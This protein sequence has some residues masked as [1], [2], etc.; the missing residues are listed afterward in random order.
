[1]KKTALLIA[2][3]PSVMNSIKSAYLKIKDTYEY[4]IDFA[5][6]AG[7]L[8]GLCEPN[9][10][11]KEWGEPWSKDVLPIVPQIWKKK[12][13]NA[14]FFNDLKKIWSEKRYDVVI[15]A[16][17]AGREGQLI[18][19]LVYEALGV[20]VPILRYWADDTTEKTIIKTLNHLVSDEQ[21]SG[22]TKASYLRLYFDWLIGIN[23]SRAGTLALERRS[24]MGRVLIPTLAL[25]YNRELEIKNFIPTDYF[26]LSATFLTSE[27][28]HYTG[29]LL[30]PASNDKSPSKYAYFNK[31]DLSN[32]KN[33]LISC[34]KGVITD[35]I[36]EDKIN[37]AP[38]L[39]NLSDLQKEC[40]NKFGYTPAKTLEIAQKLY[41]NHY[42]SYPRTESK[43]ITS[44]QAKEMPGLIVSMGK[45]DIFKPFVDNIV[46][47]KEYVT[48]ALSSKKYVDNK[49][50]SDHPALTPTSVLPDVNALSEAEKNVYVLVV[51]RF[52]AIFMPENIITQT[53]IITTVTLN[54]ANYDFR[55]IGY[56]EK[57]IG[58]K[59][60]LSLISTSPTK[61]SEIIKQELPKLECGEKVTQTSLNIEDKTTVPPKRYDNASILTAMETC[62]KQLNDEE[63]EKVLME[64][65]GLGTPATRGEILEKLFEY[66]YLERKGKTIYPTVQGIQL[67]QAL[68]GKSIISPELTAIWEKK[69]KE[70]EIGK[71]SYESFYNAMIKYIQSETN[72]LLQLQP[73]GPYYKTIGKC[74]KC[75]RDFIS[76]SKFYSCLGYFEKKDNIRSCDFGLP[77]K[78]GGR[79]LTET[80]VKA[81]I[82]GDIT[83]PKEY[84][85]SNGNKNTTSL[86]LIDYKIKFPDPSLLK[87]IVGKCPLCGG[88]VI[89]G[90]NG[91]YCEEW[92]HKDLDGNPSCSFSVYG[93]LGEST[94]STKKMMEILSDGQTKK[95]V[96]IKWASGKSYSGILYLEKLNGK[97]RFAIKPFERKCLGEC[98]YCHIGKIWEEKFT[99]ECDHLPSKGGSCLISIPKSFYGI[100]ISQK[101]ALKLANREDL[102]GKTFKNKENESY[103][104]NVTAVIDESRGFNIKKISSTKRKK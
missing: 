62:G 69:L 36:K 101:E 90:K 102:I 21:Y 50:V 14:K 45:L 51:C 77:K 100:T 33:S 20:N 35:A 9:E 18:Q 84:T 96:S 73:I 26:E 4:D 87:E 79:P 82:N 30:N 10:Y 92:N 75:G 76:T 5:S 65:A 42:L 97:Y 3:K 11:T 38:H 57:Q 13:I 22:L 54:G 48:K 68:E 53:M 71:T 8:I 46:I 37:R 94:I 25:A 64:C 23:F 72:S 32:I 78:Y 60:I 17:D 61:I 104:A 85:W 88:N 44:E 2:E 56:V 41:E 40:S 98:P 15:N 59:N 43:C 81:L 28:I 83:K 103:K 1:M 12:I 67:I 58:W 31:F 6:C 52:L 24:N 16:G 91:Y 99:Y 80:D 19:H 55:S 89:K 47:Q 29:Y 93:K 86:M 49:K 95:E 7:H 34:T 70:V 27:G 63:L 66:E 39:F 74:P